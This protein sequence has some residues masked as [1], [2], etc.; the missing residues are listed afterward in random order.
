MEN[1]GRR[2]HEKRIPYMD[3]PSGKRLEGLNNLKTGKAKKSEN[4]G[5]VELHI[6]NVNNFNIYLNNNPQNQEMLRHSTPITP[7]I[8]QF[9]KEKPTFDTLILSNPGM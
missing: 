1:R 6:G 3:N 5:G 7:K 4:Q 2:T 9:F 8:E